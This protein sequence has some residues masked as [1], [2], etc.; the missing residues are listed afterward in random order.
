ML[1]QER[2][3]TIYEL[4]R[5]RGSVKVSELQEMLSVSDM[6]VRRCLNKMA[7][8]GLLRRVHGG[9]IFDEPWEKERSFAA[10]KVRE[11]GKKLAIAQAAVSLLRDGDSIYID[12]STTC[13]ELARSLR[14]GTRLTVVTDSLA[15]LLDLKD[16]K[17]I[18][19]V[20]L[21]GQLQEDGNTLGGMLAKKNASKFSVQ[22]CF[23][24][25]SSF[26]KRSIGNAGM[27]GV[28]VKTTMIRKAARTV[29]LADA[30]KCGRQGFI[31]LCP[32]DDVDM[33]FTTEG[34]PED[35]RAAIAVQGVDVRIVTEG[36]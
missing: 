21:G 27:I 33:L 24:S 16:R 10:R 26:S 12:G 8:E 13:S 2:R 35:V 5:K 3:R 36:G 17:G 34:V 23:F 29:L 9:A 18:S 7:D 14:N 32:W 11:L 6:T 25:A 19:V 22:W 31:E 4:V 20:L 1:A 28:E 15:V 30:T